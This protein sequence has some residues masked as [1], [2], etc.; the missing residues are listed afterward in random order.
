MTITEDQ[1]KQLQEL[2]TRHMYEMGLKI[3]EVSAYALVAV[4]RDGKLRVFTT[5][6]SESD[7]ELIMGAA[8]S[9]MRDRQHLAVKQRHDFIGKPKGDA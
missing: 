4:G 8:V 6:A 1:E 9:S 2:I 3:P 5:I 7:F